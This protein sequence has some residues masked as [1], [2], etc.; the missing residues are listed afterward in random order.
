[1]SWL[2]AYDEPI[3]D[4]EDKVDNMGPLITQQV[5]LSFEVYTSSVT[6]P[7]E[8]KETIVI[9]MEV[10]PLDHTKLEDLD[11]NLGGKRG[12]DPPINPYSPGSFR[13]KV[14]EPLTIHTQPS[15]H[16]AYF[17]R[18]GIFKEKKKF[19]LYNPGDG[20]RINPDGVTSIDVINEI[21]REDLDALLVEGSK[22]LH[23]IEGTILK[24]EIFFEFYKFISMTANENYGSEF[25]IE[26]PPFKKI[27]INTDYKMKT[28]LE[29]PHTDL[30][31]KPLP[32]NLEYVF[33]EEPSFLPVII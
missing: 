6:Y 28:S 5:L 33:L 21:L 1:M 13:M 29:E 19:I 14:V 23:S 25:D 9:L 27:T 2:D 16:V 12:T 18:T 30:K 3:G 7:K 32:D 26:E 4:I 8:V 20:V 17:H 24:E 22:I 11:V 31:L 15:P 10:E